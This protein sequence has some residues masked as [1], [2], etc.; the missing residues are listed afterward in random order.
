[1]ECNFCGRD[2]TEGTGIMYVTTIGKISYFC[3][4]KCKR[5][6]ELKRKPRRTEWTKEYSLE[7]KI[8]IK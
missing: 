1:M 8:R 7:K 5:N 3:S 4:R 2:I 6:A